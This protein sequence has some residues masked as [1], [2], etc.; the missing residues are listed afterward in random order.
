[1]KRDISL[2]KRPHNQNYTSFNLIGNQGE[3]TCNPNCWMNWFCLLKSGYFS[4]PL[5]NAFIK[6]SE[7]NNWN[8]WELRTRMINCTRSKLLS[9]WLEHKVLSWTTEISSKKLF[10]WPLSISILLGRHLNVG[11]TNNYT[12]NWVNLRC[13]GNVSRVILS[14]P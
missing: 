1:M 13:K 12:N 11:E 7:M 4:L 8:S 2:R 3:N 5:H 6:H 14:F 10:L 9:T